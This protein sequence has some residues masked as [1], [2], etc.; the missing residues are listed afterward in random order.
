MEY[1]D[2]TELQHSK[3]VYSLKHKLMLE[4]LKFNCSKC[5]CFQKFF[6]AMLLGYLNPSI[7]FLVMKIISFQDVRTDLSAKTA[8]LSVAD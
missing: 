1:V 7:F 8:K 2:L 3:Q 4:F 5:F 6:K